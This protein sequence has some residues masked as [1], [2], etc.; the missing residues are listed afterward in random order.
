VK[1]KETH[2]IVVKRETEFR[3][4][5][6]KSIKGPISLH[7]IISDLSIDGIK[8]NNEITSQESDRRIVT[9]RVPKDGNQFKER[10]ATLISEKRKKESKDW[11]RYKLRHGKKNDESYDALSDKDEYRIA[12]PQGIVLAEP[13]VIYEALKKLN[14]DTR[15]EIVVSPVFHKKSLRRTGIT[16]HKQEIEYSAD[17]VRMVGFDGAGIAVLEGEQI[18]KK[19]EKPD[20]KWLMDVR[21]STKIGLKNMH[22]VP[23]SDNVGNTEWARRFMVARNNGMPLFG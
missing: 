8:F 12:L 11:V 3:F 7:H 1:N 17:E 6:T 9:W 4:D 21:E 10:S 20:K 22:I 13:S 16:K 18:L 2:N 19:G 14:F 5:I 15:D 23:E